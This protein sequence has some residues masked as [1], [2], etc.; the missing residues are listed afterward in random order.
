M[1]RKYTSADYLKIIEKL[2]KKTPNIALSSDFII[3]FPGETNN[4]FKK[5]IKLVE[6]VGFSQSYS[7]KY[8]S[9]PGTK[10]SRMNSDEISMEEKS[11][12]NKIV[13]INLKHYS[14]YHL[15]KY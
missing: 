15:I 11:R 10:S 9:R 1:N 12:L 7:F 8:S 4:D 3:G 2:R 13:S 5:T 6:E 14:I